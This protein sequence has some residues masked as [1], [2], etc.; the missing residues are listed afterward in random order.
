[1]CGL[2]VDGND[3]LATDGD[4]FLETICS[5]LVPEVDHCGGQNDLHVVS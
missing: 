5:Q 2:R 1:M 3:L 4:K